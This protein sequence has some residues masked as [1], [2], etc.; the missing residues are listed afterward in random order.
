[1]KFKN[2]ITGLIET[3]TNKDVI[4]QYKKHTDRYEEIK[5]KKPTKKE[6]E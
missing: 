3:V 4:E 6:T 2:K 1:M 5:D